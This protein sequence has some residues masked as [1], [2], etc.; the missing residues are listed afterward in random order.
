MF[1]VSLPLPHIPPGLSKHAGDIIIIYYLLSADSKLN[2]RPR[3][4]GPA[5]TACSQPARHS[6][7]VTRIQIQLLEL[8]AGDSAFQDLSSYSQ[9]HQPMT[10]GLLLT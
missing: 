6:S 2:I 1:S 3:S 4:L 8:A 5:N 10:L 7:L 9:S